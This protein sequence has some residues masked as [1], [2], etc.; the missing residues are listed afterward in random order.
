[1]PTWISLIVKEFQSYG[2]VIGRPISYVQR[3]AAKETESNSSSRWLLCP[4]EDS[5]LQRNFD[6]TSQTSQH[7][8]QS[9]YK[10]TTK[11]TIN[12]EQN[13]FID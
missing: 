2:R 12:S 3:M 5:Q 4:F 10:T 11:K 13:Q 1:M 6:G 9:S 7:Y 8:N